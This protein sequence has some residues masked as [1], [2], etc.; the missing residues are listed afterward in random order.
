MESLIK[1]QQTALL[2]K[3]K[4]PV[5]VKYELEVNN[6]NFYC[7]L[8]TDLETYICCLKIDGSISFSIKEK[9]KLF[10]KK[11]ELEWNKIVKEKLGFY[12]HY[13]QHIMH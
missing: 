13:Q 8:E 3:S 11:N 12:F 2:F 1:F 10:E 9:G 7:K 4:S 5:S 6:E